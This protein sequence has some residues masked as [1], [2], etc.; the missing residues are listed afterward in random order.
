MLIAHRI[1]LDPNNV[2]ATHLSRA[3]GVARFAYN[4][5]LAEWRRQYEACM[6]VGQRPSQA[7]ATFLAATTERNQARAVSV[8]ERSHQERASN[9]DHPVGP[10][11]PE[12]LRRSCQV[13]EVP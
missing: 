10:G 2:Q 9:G 13:S 7:I 12:L 4:W 1:A 3:A 11:I 6:Y 8:D 5:A